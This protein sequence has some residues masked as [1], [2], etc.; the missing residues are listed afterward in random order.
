MPTHTLYESLDSPEDIRAFR[1]PEG[2]SIEYKG[3]VPRAKSLAKECCAFANTNGGLLVI[4]V[5]DPR[6]GAAPTE[7]PGVPVNPDPIQKV[8]G[9]LINSVTPPVRYASKLVPMEGENRCYVLLYVEPSGDLHQV[10]VDDVGTFYRRVGSNS[11][12]MGPY[13]I[14]QRI[15]AVLETTRRL[16]ERIEKRLEELSDEYALA[17]TVVVPDAPFA[18]PTLDPAS[19]QF[20]T[21]INALVPQLTFS[22]FEPSSRGCRSAFQPEGVLTE[23]SVGRDG[24]CE[25]VD[26][27]VTNNPAEP[28]EFLDRGSY[29]QQSLGLVYRARHSPNPDIGGHLLWIERLLSSLGEFLKLSCNALRLMGYEGRVNVTTTV[30][31]TPH[32]SLILRIPYNDTMME[33]ALDTAFLVRSETSSYVR[34]METDVEPILRGMSV[35]MFESFGAER[36]SP[37]AE[38]ALR[39]F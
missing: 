33:R 35:R 16:G 23:V 36:L 29:S 17:Y 12:P 15:E 4:G 14:R 26:S 13:E 6:E 18:G 3:E 10:S 20:R 7:F 32:S 19:A 34:D 5:R 37:D 28:Y 1:Q 9:M 2:L 30:R 21:Q 39:R 25:F 38:E 24:L 8:E 27:R 11:V 31:P 22:T